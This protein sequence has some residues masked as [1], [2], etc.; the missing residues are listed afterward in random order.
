MKCVYLI[1]V[2][3]CVF[4]IYSV[5]P[6]DKAISLS[7]F[8]LF[9]SKYVWVLFWQAKDS[10]NSACELCVHFCWRVWLHSFQ[11]GLYDL[12]HNPSWDILHVYFRLRIVRACS[13]WMNK[14]GSALT[15]ITI[16]PD[17][18]ERRMYV[19]KVVHTIWGRHRGVFVHVAANLV[20]LVGSPVDIWVVFTPL[21]PDEVGILKSFSRPLISPCSPSTGWLG[22]A[23]PVDVCDVCVCVAV[24]VFCVCR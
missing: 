14:I 20:W 5:S 15:S 3:V 11:R 21:A 12:N 8:A 4:V 18:S 22:M 17:V 23:I 9:I 2:S 24:C 19:F 13:E 1:A 10:W 7:Q 6:L 16:Q